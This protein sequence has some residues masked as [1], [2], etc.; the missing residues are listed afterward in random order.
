MDDVGHEVIGGL[1]QKEDQNRRPA[2]GVL[3]NEQPFG[4]P[5]DTPLTRFLH[6]F[7]I[8]V[9]SPGIGRVMVALG[10]DSSHPGG[11]GRC[12]GD[13]ADRLMVRGV[14]DGGFRMGTS[15]IR[16][17]AGEVGPRDPVVVTPSSSLVGT[18]HH[19][20]DGRAVSRRMG[21]TSMLSR[22]TA[23]GH[24]LSSPGPGW[25]FDASDKQDSGGRRH[26]APGGA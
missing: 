4:R 17:V 11:L 21:A 20:I 15:S 14:V 19:E 9:E 13:G 5:G 7:G 25:H 8:M 2:E 12:G 23:W 24:R 26:G 6:R 22:A 10:I 18:R 3:G 16:H 1:R